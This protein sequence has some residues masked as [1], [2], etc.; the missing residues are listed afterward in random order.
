ML[1]ADIVPLFAVKLN[2]TQKPIDFVGTGFVIASS[3]LVTC[4]HCVERPLPDGCGYA[5]II[6]HG[7][8]RRTILPLEN[9]E[10][11]PSGIGLATA[12]IEL[13]PNDH[14]YLSPNAVAH[15][16]DVWAFGYPLPHIKLTDTNKRKIVVAGRFLRGYVTRPFLYDHPKFG[17]VL[18]YELDMPTPEGLSGAPLIQ[19]NTRQVIGVIYGTNDVGKI[20]ETATVN[21]Q[22][23]ERQPEVQRIVSFG[24]AHHTETLRELKGKATNGLSLAQYLA[25]VGDGV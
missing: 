22:T 25:N 4:W 21:L 14:L 23:G 5:A 15:G 10:R 13:E 1:Q 7:P 18:S 24:L 19:L 8:G 2:G 20:E 12:N 11:D 6:F 9:L 16:T 3:L 17:A